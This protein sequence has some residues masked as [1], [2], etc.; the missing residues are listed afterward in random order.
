MIARDLRDSW[1]V[2][3]QCR[4]KFKLASEE[5]SEESEKLPSTKIIIKF[6][7]VSYRFSYINNGIL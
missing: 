4:S 1:R 6:N 5:Y 2:L 7:D 3:I